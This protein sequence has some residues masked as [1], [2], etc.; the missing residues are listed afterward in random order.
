MDKLLFGAAY[1]REYLP[2]ERLHE[3]IKLMKEAGINYVRIAEST[4]ST[5]EPQ[6]G[7][8]DFSSVLTVLDEMYKNGIAVI[9]GTPTYALPA[10]LAK[11][12]SGCDGHHQ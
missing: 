10:W 2:M 3:D 7:E 8:F 12:I 6:E 1:Y 4:W 9:I 5:F 11:K